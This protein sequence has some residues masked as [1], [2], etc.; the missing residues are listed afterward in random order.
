[1][2]CKYR[3]EFDPS[4]PFDEIEA[5]MALAIVGVEALHGEPEVQLNPVHA[6]DE[7]TR[8]CVIDA[9]SDIGRDL[10]RLFLGYV[11]REF[12]ADAFRVQRISNPPAPLAT[13]A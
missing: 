5:S 9:E 6:L 4:V 1:M 7:S 11:R 8:R 3:Y 10:N 2:S 12:G 13:A